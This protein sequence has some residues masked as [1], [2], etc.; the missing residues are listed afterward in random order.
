MEFQTH[1]KIGKLPATPK[2]SGHTFSGWYT[3]KTGGSKIGVNTKPTKAV[4]Y[5]AQWKKADKKKFN[6]V[7]KWKYTDPKIYHKELTF[8]SNGSYYYSGIIDGWGNIAEF[9]GNYRVTGDRIITS[10]SYWR[11]SILGSNEPWEKE[12]GNNYQFLSNDKIT[13]YGAYTYKRV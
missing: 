10:N 8:Y 13:E 11:T 3:K 4:T 2:R 9:K 12:E 7:G 5:Y 1:S 6:A